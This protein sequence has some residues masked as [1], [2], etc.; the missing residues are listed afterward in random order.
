[1]RQYLHIL[2]MNGGGCH[3]LYHSFES[4]NYRGQF[5]LDLDFVY[6]HCCKLI[7]ACKFP[8]IRA[9]RNRNNKDF[10]RER[11]SD[12]VF[13]MH[14]YRSQE[15]KACFL[16]GNM[17]PVPKQISKKK[18]TSIICSTVYR[19]PSR[20]LPGEYALVAS[21]YGILWEAQIRN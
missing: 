17:I 5:S 19:N 12:H 6:K 16:P 9:E 2:Y 11:L 21:Y 20:S 4:T 3:S 18:K 14:L 7:F 10:S 15:N 13:F 8:I 1:M